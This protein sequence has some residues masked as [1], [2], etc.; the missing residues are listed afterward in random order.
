MSGEWET[1]IGLEI[2][3]QLATKSKIFSGSATAYGAEPNTQAD[4]VDLGYPGVLPVLNAEV[5][6]MAAKFVGKRPLVAHNAGFDG[7]FWRAELA[8]LRLSHAN[9]FLCTLKLARR[10]YPEL[11]GH[12]LQALREDLALRSVG[13]AHRAAADVGVTVELLKRIKKDLGAQHGIRRVGGELLFQVQSVPRAKVAA[14]VR[15]FR[16]K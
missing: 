11:G 10:V 3:A 7:G 1:V 14:T 5:V 15:A 8:K 4:L 12:S 9:P 13:R 6:R 16:T 2:H